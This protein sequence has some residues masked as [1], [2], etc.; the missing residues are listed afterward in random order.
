VNGRIRPFGPAN[1]WS[2]WDRNGLLCPNSHSSIVN[3]WELRSRA[4]EFGHSLSPWQ[5]AVIAETGGSAVLAKDRQLAFTADVHRLI[6]WEF[7]GVPEWSPETGTVLVSA[8]SR[9]VWD[10]SPPPEAKK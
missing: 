3:W 4:A 8:Y 6:G 9:S 5:V 10:A 1:H 2:P 7:G